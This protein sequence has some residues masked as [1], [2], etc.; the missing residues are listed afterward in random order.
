VKAFIFTSSA[1]M[2]AGAQHLNL[3][4]SAPL[5]ETD[6]RSHPYA[7]TKAQADKMVLAANKSPHSE[8][9]TKADWQDQLR[10]SCIRLPIVY[11][12]H[13]RASIPGALSALQRGQTNFQLGDGS[14]MWDFCST[15]NAAEA[16][17]LLGKAPLSESGV[18]GSARVDGEAFNIMDDDPHLFWDFARSIWK[19]AGHE[20]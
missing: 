7:R 20:A 10:T 4:E 15:E 3:D 9:E 14:N 19:F 16:H 2:A 18:A 1:T 13:D 5:A 17:I 11:G 8:I 6:P 12:D